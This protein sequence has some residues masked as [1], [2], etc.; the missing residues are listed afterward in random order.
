MKRLIISLAF[1]AACLASAALQAS[2]YDR[3]PGSRSAAMGGAFCA[4]EGALD[5]M[6][7]PAMRAP[8]RG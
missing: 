1:V 3:N 6:M 7:S 2:P 8:L 5:C 4:A